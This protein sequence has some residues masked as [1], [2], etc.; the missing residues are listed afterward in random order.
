ML[1]GLGVGDSGMQLSIFR[2][3][4][5]KMIPHRKVAVNAPTASLLKFRETSEAAS[6]VPNK[7]GNAILARK[8]IG[9]S[10]INNKVEKPETL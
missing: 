8:T 1:Y 10:G 5:R 6:I 4:S 9:Y 2:I 7:I 3:E